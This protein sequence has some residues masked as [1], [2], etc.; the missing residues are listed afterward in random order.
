LAGLYLAM[1]DFLDPSRGPDQGGD[2]RISPAFFFV[3]FGVGFLLGAVG[4]VTKV[5]ALVAAGVLLILLATVVL[6]VAL[7]L[8]R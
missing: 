4:H 5:K 7:H 3:L 6:P 2:F 8:T 1:S